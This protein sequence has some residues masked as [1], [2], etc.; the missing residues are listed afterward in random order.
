M[1]NDIETI[2]IAIGFNFP[3]LSTANLDDITTIL[4]FIENRQSTDF[5][6]EK[7]SLHSAVIMSATKLF[8]IKSILEQDLKGYYESNPELVTPVLLTLDDIDTELENL[9][10][11]TAKFP[12]WPVYLMDKHLE[13]EDILAVFCKEPEEIDLSQTVGELIIAHPEIIYYPFEG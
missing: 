3:Q 4:E 10:S 5:F 1:K 12:E 6:N 8:L 7:I 9:R 2:I 11:I 13:E